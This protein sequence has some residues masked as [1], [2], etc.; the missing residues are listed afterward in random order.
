MQKACHGTVR[1]DPK[2]AQVCVRSHGENSE[3]PC[4]RQP[5]QQCW[6]S[7]SFSRLATYANVIAARFCVY[8]R[9]FSSAG[10]APKKREE[11]PLIFGASSVCA[12]IAQKRCEK[13]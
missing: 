2:Y 8:V 7:V 5:S 4:V 12:D 13:T 3:Q 9:L 6:R 10:F 11:D 1:S